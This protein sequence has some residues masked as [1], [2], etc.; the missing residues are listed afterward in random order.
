MDQGPASGDEATDDFWSP[1]LR[2][3]QFKG[4]EARF[5]P[6]LTDRQSQHLHTVGGK[7]WALPTCLPILKR[8]LVDHK[9]GWK[10]PPLVAE[11]VAGKP[12]LF[13]PG[14]KLYF[15]YSSQGVD[16]HD[17]VRLC[18]GLGAGAGG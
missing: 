16:H 9:V 4:L 14:R 15:R 13:L 2:H 3:C 11:G 1:S 5:R 10:I 18:P 17:A 12:G 7:F 8:L 6:P